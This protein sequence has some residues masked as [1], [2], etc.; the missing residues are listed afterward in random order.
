MTVFINSNTK[1]MCQ[2]L[3]GRSGIYHIE[4]SLKYGTNVVCGVTPGK[5]GTMCL[6]LPVFNSVMEASLITKADVSIIFVP[7]SCCKDSI[8]EAIEANMRLIVCITEGIPVLDMIY[9]K[10]L[11]I[12]RNINT[13]LIGPNS[14]GFVIPGKCR[15]GIMPVDIHRQGV[16]GIVSRS[17]TL[18][19][20]AI[21]QTTTI[22]LGQSISIGIG[23]DPIVG[24][25]FI[26]I[27]KIL[28]S[29]FRTKII[30]LI[31]EI[32]GDSEESAALFI[33]KYIKK[34]VVAFISG[35][36][37]PMGKRMGHSG[38]IISAHSGAAETKMEKLESAGVLVVKSILNIGDILLKRYNEFY[39]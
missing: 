38:A 28:N 21:Y 26:D 14:P 3:T 4:K 20:E 5:G 12:N 13:M 33:K 10:S 1:I 24:S 34:P 31:G 2:G 27:L 36:S 39:K 16:V 15:L 17:G 9:I 32:G 37:A 23:G 35:I 11:L 6:G 30:L 8:I 18:T 29:D 19:Y 22:G 25:N 7:S